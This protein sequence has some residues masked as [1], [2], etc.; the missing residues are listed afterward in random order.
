MEWYGLCYRPSTPPITGHLHRP[1]T[2]PYPSTHPSTHPPTYPP[3]YP[4]PLHS[5]P[6]Q[7][8]STASYFHSIPWLLS[9]LHPSR[10]PSIHPY[11]LTLEEMRKNN[12]FTPPNQRKR[13][14]T[15]K[16]RGVGNLLYLELLSRA[17]AL[18]IFLRMK[19]DGGCVISWGLEMRDGSCM[20]YGK[21][22]LVRMKMIRRLVRMR[23]LRI[24]WGVDV[25]DIWILL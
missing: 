16:Y 14:L 9:T 6:W 18:G 7:L 13:F 21:R 4:R 3:T 5:M 23:R 19:M 2:H 8:T 25:A 11:F 1:S 15:L 20:M 17:F 12:L 24:F 10:S 22:R